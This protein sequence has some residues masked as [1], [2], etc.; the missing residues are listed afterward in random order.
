MKEQKINYIHINIEYLQT[1]IDIFKK[2]IKNN[3]Y[4]SDRYLSNNVLLVD[5]NKSFSYISRTH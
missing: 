5:L 4:I 1:K 2:N 3:R